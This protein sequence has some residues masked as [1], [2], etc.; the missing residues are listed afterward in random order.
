MTTYLTQLTKG[1]DEGRID[2][3]WLAYFRENFRGEIN[4]QFLE[5]F[6]SSGLTKADI[7]RKLNRRPEQVT[8]WFAAPCNL[9]ADTIS[10]LALALG[11]VPKVRFEKAGEEKSNGQVH[12]FIERLDQSFEYSATERHSFV[13]ERLSSYDSGNSCSSFA[14]TT[15]SK[16]S[17]RAA[18]SN[19]RVKEVAVNA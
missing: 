8:R 14:V 1:T 17:T 2:K 5:A 6:R 18:S 16:A 9:E 7:A 11:L 15:Q 4:D 19:A 12:N 3:Y 10:D 13:I